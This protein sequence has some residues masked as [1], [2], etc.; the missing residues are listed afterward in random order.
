[1]V[2]KE[3]FFFETI[4]QGVTLDNNEI[5]KLVDTFVCQV[6]KDPQVV[7]CKEENIVQISWEPVSDENTVNPVS[8]DDDI[9]K[10]VFSLTKSDDDP[11]NNGSVLRALLFNQLSSLGYNSLVQVAQKVKVY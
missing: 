6:G 8:F 11:E 5:I 9:M 3:P 1:M 7:H 4:R 2:T 10:K